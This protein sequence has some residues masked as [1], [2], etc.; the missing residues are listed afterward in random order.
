MPKRRSKRRFLVSVL[1]ALAAGG[2]AATLGASARA[3]TVPDSSSRKCTLDGTYGSQCI[4]VWGSGRQV[5]RIQASFSGL[6]GMLDQ[7]RWRVDLERYDCD[8]VH[9]RK[10]E[11]PAAA[12]WHGAVRA[13]TDLGDVRF[14]QYGRNRYW[15]TFVSLPHTF[16][17]NVWLCAELAFYNST[18]RKWVYNAA[19]LIHGLRAC[20]A[21]HS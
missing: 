6:A 10:S 4:E 9:R 8:P 11:C 18:A 7:N 16:G 5:S 19:G 15:P 13:A 1:V 3:S 14:A 17:S 21:V 12:T 2:V 20:V